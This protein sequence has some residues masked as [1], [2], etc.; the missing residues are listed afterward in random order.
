MNKRLTANIMLV[1]TA[2]IWGFAFVAQSKA[3]DLIGCFT[4]NGIR[5]MI[6]AISLIPVIYIFERR[7]KQKYLAKD[8]L[9]VKYGII[10]GVILFVASALQQFGVANMVI[11]S[12]AAFITGIYT[13]IVPVFG[14]FMKKKTSVNTWIGAFFAVAGLYFVSVVGV[15]KIEFGDII[16]FAG[17]FFW[18]LHIIAIDKYV[19]K[20]N[21]IMYSSVQFFTC[22]VIN[23]ILMFV[24]EMGS[25]SFANIQLAMIPI[26]YAGVMSSG[27]AYTLQVLGQKNSKPTEA[28]IIFSLE[29]VFAAIGCWMLLGDRMSP[30]SMLGCVLIFAG[31]IL[32]QLDFK[33]ES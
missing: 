12:K 25:F 15:E 30:V 27:V 21:P 19:D 14:L 18:A 22:G 17:A 32:S 31:I 28:A 11:D 5:F 9:T 16:C 4:F 24:F 3:S 29:S 7:G 33:K 2:L 10:T 13:V 8:K 1:L 26:L 6:G 20:V 23:L